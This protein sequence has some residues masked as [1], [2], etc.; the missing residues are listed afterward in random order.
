[1]RARAY[2]VKTEY[3][4]RLGVVSAGGLQLQV[5]SSNAVYS[6]GQDFQMALQ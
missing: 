4:W 5:E 3:V 1:M 2:Q 6:I